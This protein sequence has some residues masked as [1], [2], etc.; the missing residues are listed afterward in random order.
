VIGPLY[1][2]DAA[3]PGTMALPDCDGRLPPEDY[4]ALRK[5]RVAPA[6]GRVFFNSLITSSGSNAHGQ[7]ENRGA[8]LS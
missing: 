3:G 8:F 4:G 6:L 7:V 1:N 2:H 5:R